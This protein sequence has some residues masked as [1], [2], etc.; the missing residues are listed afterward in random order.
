MALYSQRWNMPGETL[1]TLE[2]GQITDR[3]DPQKDER[4]V[5]REIEADAFLSEESAVSLVKWLNGQISKL[6]ELRQLQESAEEE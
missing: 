2:E 3:A 6:R 1:L 5:I 4:L